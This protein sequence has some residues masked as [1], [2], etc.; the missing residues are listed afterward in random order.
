M[1]AGLALAL[2]LS[3]GLATARAGGLSERPLKADHL[4]GLYVRPEDT[5]SPR[6]G[7][8][9]LGGSEGGLSPVVRAEARALAAQ[10]YAVL[11]LAYFGL[12]GLPE[13]VQLIPVEYFE[14]AISWLRHQPGVDPRRI[15]IMGTSVGGEAALLVAS[16]DPRIR[17]VVA[18]VPSGIVW[19]G[20]GGWG[21]RDPASSFTL[22]AKALPGLPHLFSANESVF[23]GYRQ[24]LATL[25]EH[26]AARM[27]L[28]AINGPVMLIC[29]G[30][31][32][33]WPS[34]PLAEDAA[35]DLRRGG[36]AYPVLL[37]AYPN[38]G[39]AVFGPPIAPADPFYADL[40]ALGGTAAAN[41][42][43][44][45]DA[46]PRALGF[47]RA[48]FSRQDS[49]RRARD[50]ASAARASAKKSGPPKLPDLRAMRSP[51]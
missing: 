42:A 12:N 50:Q 43:A 38:A 39:H 47:L 49:D 28:R 40:G 31:D 46:W 45:A 25:P 8:L 30:K 19:Q 34:C 24:G 32:D 33:V 9:L 20:I 17:A 22:G 4:I 1:R 16:H 48:A 5:A 3:L 23:A 51:G 26:P 27:P 35:A 2:L 21:A 41:D 14:R 18:A 11:Q 36:F 15:G 13:S 10:G 29:G 7:M 37:L 6:P 44:R